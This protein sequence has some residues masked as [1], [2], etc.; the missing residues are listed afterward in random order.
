[1]ANPCSYHPLSSLSV[2]F[3]LIPQSENEEAQREALQLLEVTTIAMNH[4]SNGRAHP[5]SG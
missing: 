4:F 1:M 5:V 3:W 2:F